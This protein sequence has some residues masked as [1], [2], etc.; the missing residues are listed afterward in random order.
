MQPSDRWRRQDSRRKEPERDYGEFI[1]EYQDSSEIEPKTEPEST[2]WD[3]FEAERQ[4]NGY[5]HSYEALHPQLE[6]HVDPHF[7]FRYGSDDMD[8]DSREERAEPRR[9]QRRH[10]RRGY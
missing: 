8:F 9:R 4:K 5:R 1:N 7:D 10:L 6:P 3:S 2:L